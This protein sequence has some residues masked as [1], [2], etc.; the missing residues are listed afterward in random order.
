MLALT[1]SRVPEIE[2]LRKAAETA[3]TLGGSVSNDVRARA[4]ALRK[5]GFATEDIATAIGVHE[6]TLWVASIRKTRCSF[7]IGRSRI[8]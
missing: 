2:S 1:E 6:T 8:K 7:S 3:R 5:A 4:V